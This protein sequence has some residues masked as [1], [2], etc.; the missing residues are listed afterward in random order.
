MY[1]VHIFDFVRI[2]FLQFISGHFS[3]FLVFQNSVR[4]II[5]IYA[6]ITNK[7]VAS[8]KSAFL[9]KRRTLHGPRCGGTRQIKISIPP[10]CGNQGCTVLRRLRAREADL[11]RLISMTLNVQWESTDTRRGGSVVIRRC[12]AETKDAGS[13][14]ATPSVTLMHTENEKRP[15]VG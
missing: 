12:A 4:P 13:T 7:G 10:T 5:S 14:P 1:K 3:Y 11:W 15:S 2:F 6:A 9:W 8:A